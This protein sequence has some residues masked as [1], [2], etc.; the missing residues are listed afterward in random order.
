MKFG[1][2]N[3]VAVKHNDPHKIGSTMTNSKE[4]TEM[5]TYP[6]ILEIG[7]NLSLRVVGLDHTPKKVHFKVL[8]IIAKE[9]K[10]SIYLVCELSTK[11]LYCL[12]K[13]EVIK[14]E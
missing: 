13:C 11:F 9:D 2:I 12:K 14:S 7:Q 10:T 5:Y 8:K 6:K 3:P 1:T 4:S